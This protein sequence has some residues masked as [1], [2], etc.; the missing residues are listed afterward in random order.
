MVMAKRPAAARSPEGAESSA[1]SALGNWPVQLALVHPHAPYLQDADLLVAA[2][3]TAFALG[4]FHHRLLN[5]R[6][7]VIA[8]PKLD[9]IPPYIGKLAELFRANRLRSLEVARMEVPCC[10]GI[11]RLV[12]EAL[13]AAGVAV[14]FRETVV[15]VEGEV[16]EEISHP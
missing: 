15:G 2:D 7:L 8:C 3:C 4:N 14:P 12:E 9:D 6:T 13:Q 5:G 11:V 16:L 10:R 1:P